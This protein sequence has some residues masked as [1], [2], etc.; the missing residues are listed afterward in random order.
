MNPNDFLK[1]AP[2]RLV[3]TSQ[4]YWSFFVNPLPPELAWSGALVTLHSEAERELARLALAGGDF[5]HPFI[6]T[7]PFIRNEAVISSRIEGTQATLEDLYSY[8]AEQMSFLE[9][10]SDAREVYNYVRALEHGLERVKTLPISLRLIRELHARLMEGVRGEIMT[11]GAFRRSQNWIGPAGCTLETAAYVPPPVEEM[12]RSLDALEKF[13]HAP[14]DLPALTRLGLIHYQFEAIH[15]FLDGNGRVGRL[16]ISLLLCQWGLLPR[17]VLY[18]S[19][20]FERYRSE[21]YERLLAVSQ[22]GEW[23]GWLRFFLTGVRDQSREAAIRVQN[24]GQL[25]ERYRR[26]LASR[27][28]VVRLSEAVDFLIGNPIFTVRGL[29]AGMDLADFKTAQRY[30]VVLEEAGILREVTGRKRNR[31]YRADEVFN[32]IKDPLEFHR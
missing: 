23:E 17:P 14:F 7:R 11:P 15:P 1:S 3:K 29:Q 18:L 22:R 30:V 19:A 25:R 5:P 9:P 16:L 8:E 26:H 28:S 21:Y 24:L 4:G 6:L 31:L 2:G 20:Y 10:A 27:R 32:G 13:I 12:H